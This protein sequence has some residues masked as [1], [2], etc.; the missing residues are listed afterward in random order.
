MPEI[1]F[2]CTENQFRS[3]LAAALFEK[4]LRENGIREGWKVRSAGT[5]VTRNT[6]AHPVAL[7]EGKKWGL[8]LSQHA[9]HEVTASLVASADLVIVM[10]QGQK[11][12]LQFEFPGQ[13]QKICMLT[14][15]N[16]IED[17]EIP[18]PVMTDL[19]TAEAFIEDL[20]AEIDKAYDEI[21][22]RAAFN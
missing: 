20:S 10:T 19:G 21:L 2:V 6:G 7:R 4:R 5:W 8:D 14:E 13:Q 15:L 3:P 12:A 22:R 17:G 1:L 18:D 16:G 9:T 11:E